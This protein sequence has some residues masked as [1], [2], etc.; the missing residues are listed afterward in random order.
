MDRGIANPSLRAAYFAGSIVRGVSLKLGIRTHARGWVTLYYHAVTAAERKEFDMH[1]KVAAPRAARTS[2][3]GVSGCETGPCVC[4]TFDDGFASLLENAIASLVARRVPATVFAVSDNLGRKPE[5]RLAPGDPDAGERVM[6][7]AELRS[8]PEDLITIGS[9]TATHKRLDELP[10]DEARIEL[11]RSK[12]SLE[13]VL[14]RPVTALAFPHGAYTDEVVQAAY[15]AGYRQLF[16]IEACAHPGPLPMGLIGRFAA[17]PV[18]TEL[19]FRLKI[20]GAYDWL[21]H[22]RHTKRRLM[23]PSEPTRPRKSI[24]VVGVR[25]DI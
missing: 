18:E 7:A 23:D 9:H 13:D 12:K 5:W 17:S 22:V 8:L 14:G 21:Y 2:D 15:D 20:A 19:E 25:I 10:L 16:T 24:S 4:F 11:T 6:T 3:I 1:V